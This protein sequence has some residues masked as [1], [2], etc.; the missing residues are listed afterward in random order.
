MDTADRLALGEDRI[1]TMRELSQRTAQVID[2]INK[3]GKPVLLTRH[4]RFL[5]VITPLAPRQVESVVLAHLG[6]FL[7]EAEEGVRAGLTSEEL[8]SDLERE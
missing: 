1:V 4:G 8:V 2:E 7:R 3:N 6:D 5:A